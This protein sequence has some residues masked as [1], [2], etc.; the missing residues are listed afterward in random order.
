LIMEG[1][2]ATYKQLPDNSEVYDQARALTMEY[3]EKKNLIYLI[4]EAWSKQGD[5]EISGVCIEY[6]TEQSR[7][8]AWS[9]S[10]QCASQT[11]NINR[12]DPAAPS[13]RVKIIIRNKKTEE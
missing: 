6:N 11:I 12:D 7:A 13:A 8:R 4:K 2:P 5:G 10:V 1:Q 9:G 3:H